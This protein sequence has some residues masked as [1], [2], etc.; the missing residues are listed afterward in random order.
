MLPRVKK[1]SNEFAK[2]KT[3]LH[4]LFYGIEAIFILFFVIVIFFSIYSIKHAQNSIINCLPDNLTAVIHFS[5]AQ[6]EQISKNFFIN[7][8]KKYFQIT[9]DD[10]EKLLSE[11]KEAAIIFFEKDGKNYPVIILPAAEKKN[12]IYFWASET[13]LTQKQWNEKFIVLAKE[14]QIL[15]N[16]NQKQFKHQRTLKLFKQK[17]G[18]ML[19]FYLNHEKIDKQNNLIDEAVKTNLNKEIFIGI[20]KN[21]KNYKLK[22]SDTENNEIVSAQINNL[23]DVAQIDK[24]TILSL[25][26]YLPARENL[27]SFFIKNGVMDNSVSLIKFLEETLNNQKINFILL[28][29][30]SN[31]NTAAK[32]PHDQLMLN[33]ENSRFYYILTLQNNDENKKN[34]EKFKITAINYLDKIM[35]EEKI[36]TLP[37]GTFMTELWSNPLR[38]EFKESPF[39][40]SDIIGD[41]SKSTI[42]FELSYA[43]TSNLILLS[44]SKNTL[45]TYLSNNLTRADAKNT[46]DENFFVNIDYLKDK[47]EIFEILSLFGNYANGV[48][49]E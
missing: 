26:T 29:N 16:L 31:H 10:N 19:T 3:T 30:D 44:N 4:R 21:E 42:D 49:K 24:N 6:N 20:A 18:S 25:E 36:A 33:G 28:K 35:P 43:K 46:G 1:I 34:L 9:I 5:F 22:I 8:L 48:I 14:P 39:Q 41:I 7:R 38:F 2:L 15:K 12:T 17:N 11:L 23:A 45:K 37:D 13:G 40:L 47:S 32:N 27:T